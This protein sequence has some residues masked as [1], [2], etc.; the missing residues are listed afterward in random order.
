MAKKK[1]VIVESPSKAGTIKNYLGSDYSVVSSLGHIRDLPKSKLG[2][3]IENDFKPDYINIRGKGTLI[4]QLKK[5]AANASVV[6]LATDPDREGEA[7]SWHLATALNL[8]P[9]KAERVTFNEITKNVIKE[10][11][12]HPRSI[13][14]DLVNAQ[15]ARRILDRI[16]GYKLSPFLWKKIRSGL[17]AGRVQS[18]VT[19]IIVDREN[20][21]RAFKPEEYWT[22]SADLKTDKN[23][24]F[25]A[26]F[27]SK[28]DDA[29]KATV[30]TKEEA[31]AIIAASEKSDFTVK[32]VKNQRKQKNPLPP[33]I[34]S[35]LQQDAARKLNFQASRT[36]RV[37]Q[38]LYEGISLGSGRGTTGLITYMR[39]DSTRVS[40]SAL[41]SARKYITEKFGEDFVPE[42]PRIFKSRAGAQDAHEA[43]RPTHPEF[44]PEDIEKRLSPDQFK[45][46]KLIWSRFIASQMAPATIDT[47]TAD[48][49]SGGNIFRI[50]GSTVLFNGYLAVYSD[51]DKTKEDKLPELT[52]GQKLTLEKLISEQHFTEPPARYNEA[53]L[54]KYLEEK[55]IGRPSTY[56]TIITTIIGREYV[57]RDGKALKPTNLGEVTTELMSEKFPEIVD[58]AFTADMETKLDEIENGKAEMNSVLRDFYSGFEKELQ[59]ASSDSERIKIPDVKTDI[60]CEKCGATMVI[61]TGRFGKFAACP[62]Y[63]ECKNTKPLDKNG[64]L[65][66][67]AEPPKPTGE[68]CPLCKTGDVVLRTGRFG[69]FYACSDYP[70]CRYTKQV[71]KPIGVKCPDCGAEIVAKR[72][73]NRAYFYSCER[74][75]E[76]DFSSW[77]LPLNEKCPNC[78]HILYYKKAKGQAVCKNKDCGFTKEY[79]PEK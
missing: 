43:I 56:A 37:A 70:K 53:S 76:C 61:K 71:T 29:K 30:S 64:Q 18:A 35:S 77:D 26:N 10:A 40:D 59:S 54:V 55:G 14:M 50:N 16:V 31:D 11:I 22:I 5:E 21:I 79:T 49:L 45:L 47:V 51:M 9:E 44:V 20:E 8:P 12:K 57:E 32:T 60:I 46:Y 24:K 25:T 67:P 75:P 34:T 1:L 17:S 63:P 58:S 78:D 38:E 74:Y 3:E 19:K 2:V 72:G 6:Y 73:K 33:F 41:D 68:K 15:Q 13:D 62:N 42:K 65:K 36:M 48:I 23:E 69:G 7:I 52:E 27:F 66:K 39:T 28:E 4:N